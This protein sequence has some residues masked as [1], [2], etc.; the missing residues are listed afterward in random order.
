MTS[1]VL[2]FFA[3]FR[4]SRGKG[5]TGNASALFP[6]STSALNVALA[7]TGAGAT[8]AN[9]AFL[10]Q[11][12][13]LASGTGETWDWT[14]FTNIANDTSQSFSAAIRFFYVIHSTGSLASTITI[15]NA[16]VASNKWTP[17][18]WAATTTLTFKPG[19]GIIMLA[20]TSTGLP[21]DGT[22]KQ[23]LVTNDDGSHAATYEIGAFG[24]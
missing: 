21:V 13:S 14:S 24:S 3:G 9:Q 19:E 6:I 18:S 7:S 11:S 8:L 1:L 2:S 16:G 23:L 20:P 12:R 4:K 22:H 10:K 15:G 17:F 5:I